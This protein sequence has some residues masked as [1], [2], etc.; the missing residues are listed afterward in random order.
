MENTDKSTINAV[1]EPWVDD[2]TMCT[3]DELAAARSHG[4]LPRQLLELKIRVGIRKYPDGHEHHVRAALGETLRELMAVGAKEIGIPLLPPA[5]AEPLDSL[6]CELA[7]NHGQ[8][9]DPIRDLEKPL[10]IAIVDGRSRH[11]AIEYRL[12]VQINTRWGVAPSEHA[13][14]RELL[15]AFGLNPAEY[16]LYAIEPKNGS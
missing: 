9:S 6:R 5:P 14:P 4:R 3:P 10:W 15:T 11:F 12:I 1:N 2:I 16:S 13:T 7:G 8:W